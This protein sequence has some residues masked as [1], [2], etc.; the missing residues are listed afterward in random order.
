MESAVALLERL[1]A[2]AVVCVCVALLV[3]QFIGA[4]RRVRWGAR[5]RRASR[6]ARAFTLRL[7]HWPA[8][9]RAAR[10]E[11]EEAIRRARG[12]GG[13]WDGNVQAP[14]SLRKSRKLH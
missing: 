1:F 14:K 5:L 3:R 12:D 2:G 10:R 4:S 9:R 11:T 7:C 6:A 13:A 8:V